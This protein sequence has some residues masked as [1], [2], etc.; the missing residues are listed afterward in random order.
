MTK[1]EEVVKT[2]KRAKFFQD[3]CTLI[4]WCADQGIEFMPFCFYRDPEQQLLEYRKG[5]SLTKYSRHQDWLAMDLVLVLKGKLIWKECQE[6]YTAGEKWESMGHYW[7]KRIE[8]LNDIY[9]F[10]W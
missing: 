9:H 4:S 3:L 5:R 10:E 1:I 8:K 2:T 7:G 6:Y